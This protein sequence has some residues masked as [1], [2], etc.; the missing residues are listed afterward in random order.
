MN[1]NLKKIKVRTLKNMFWKRKWEEFEI[2]EVLVNKN[3]IW[4]YL[5]LVE[6]K[7][8]KKNE[9]KEKSKKNKKKEVKNTKNKAILNSDNEITK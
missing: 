5:E 9:K 2:L 1:P 8:V 7:E 3:F 4:K 6:E